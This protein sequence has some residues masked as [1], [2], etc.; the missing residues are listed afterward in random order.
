MEENT[1]KA[2]FEIF[3]PY[4]NEIM[5]A[6]RKKARKGLGIGL[7]VSSLFF[8]ALSIL[9]STGK[10]P[11]TFAIVLFGV[12]AVICV[13][14]GVTLLFLKPSNPKNDG[15]NIKYRFYKDY[16]NINQDTNLEKKKSKVLSACLYRPYKNKQY[17]WKIYEYKD[18]IQLAIYTGT[19]NGFPQYSHQIIPKSVLSPEEL[20]A[21][22]LFLKAKIGE[23]YLEK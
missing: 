9:A 23:D 1:E 6:S 16:L 7:M 13:G 22:I 3:V 11:S 17:V 5:T 14:V 4:N 20:N 2:L 10:K 21:L 12:I 18:R 19:Y 8:V 15:K